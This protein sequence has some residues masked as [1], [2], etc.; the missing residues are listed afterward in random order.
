LPPPGSEVEVPT[1][2]I[3]LEHTVPCRVAQPEKR[4]TIRVRKVAAIV[5]N[6]ETSV[7]IQWVPP[8]KSSAVEGPRLA[9]QSRIVRFRAARPVSPF[10]GFFRREAYLPVP[11]AVPKGFDTSG[12]SSRRREIDLNPDVLQRV[13]IV[14]RTCELGFEPRPAKNFL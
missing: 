11:G 5:G 1:P 8:G 7:Q 14:A 3:S 4:G 13:F 6:R 10:S 9:V 12:L 2:G